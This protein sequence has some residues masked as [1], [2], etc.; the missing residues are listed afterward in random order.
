MTGQVLE[1]RAVISQLHCAVVCFSTEDCWSFNY[2][3][4]S[5]DCELNKGL[6]EPVITA[7]ETSDLY[8]K[9]LLSVQK[10]SVL[11]NNTFTASSPT[12]YRVVCYLY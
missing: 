8:S 10:P 11:I 5:G 12:D 2:I 7:D 6:Q 3:Q 4:S 1:T 9:Y